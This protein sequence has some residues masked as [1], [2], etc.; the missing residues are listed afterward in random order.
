MKLMKREDDF[1]N[2]E[3]S[4]AEARKTRGLP[5]VMTCAYRFTWYDSSATITYDSLLSDFKN[6]DDPDGGDGILDIKTGVY[7]VIKPAGYYTITFSGNAVLE[8]G[9]RL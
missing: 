5:Y 4:L 8:P 7:T 2:L 9:D 1:A 3:T 6:S